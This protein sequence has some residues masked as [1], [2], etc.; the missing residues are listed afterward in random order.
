MNPRFQSQLWKCDFIHV[1]K[2][3]YLT[4]FLC[5]RCLADRSIQV[6]LIPLSDLARLGFV[7]NFV[8]I[9]HLLFFFIT[10]FYSSPK[11]RNAQSYKLLGFLG[12]F[13]FS[14]PH[15]HAHTHTTSREQFIMLHAYGQVFQSVCISNS[16]T[17]GYSIL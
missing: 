13:A 14:W 16:A 17:E 3:T 7:R 2:N 15:H 9:Q 12:D 5:S 1:C 6:F 8:T 4:L 10:F 11:P